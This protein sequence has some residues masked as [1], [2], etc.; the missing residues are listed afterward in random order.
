MVFLRTLL[1]AAFFAIAL[2]SLWA[3]G[4]EAVDAPHGCSFCTTFEASSSDVANAALPHLA[5]ASTDQADP[6]VAETPY[7]RTF[8]AHPVRSHAAT[9][10]QLPDPLAAL[11]RPPWVA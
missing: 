4:G 1:L 2:S 11:L 3:G 8:S 10:L 9:S 7:V 5:E 6:D